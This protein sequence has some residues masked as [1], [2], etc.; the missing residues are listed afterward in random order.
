MNDRPRFYSRPQEP[1]TPLPRRAGR[2]SE[3]AGIDRGAR[4]PDRGRVH[5]G[6]TDPNPPNRKAMNIMPPTRLEIEEQQRQEKRKRQARR[7]RKASRGRRFSAKQARRNH[8]NRERAAPLTR[9]GATCFP[10]LASGQSRERD[11]VALAV[12]VAGLQPSSPRWPSATPLPTSAAIG[13]P[14]SSLCTPFSASSS[15]HSTSRGGTPTSFRRTPFAGDPSSGWGYLPAMLVFALLPIVPAITVFI[16]LHIALSAVAA[17]VLGRLTGFGPAGAFVAGAAYAFP[18]LVP[19]AGTWSSLPAH[20][21]AADSAHR[22]R[23]RPARQAARRDALLA[24]FSPVSPS[25]RSWRPGSAR[26]AYYALLVIGGWVA[27]RTLVTPPSGWTL[28]PSSARS[29]WHRRERPADWHCPERGGASGRASTPTP[30]PMWPVGSTPDSPAGPIPD[31]GIPIGDID[32]PRS[33]GG[34]S[35]ANW[36]YVGAAVAA[37]AFLAP[38]VAPRWPP[39]LFWFARRRGGIILF[40]PERTPSSFGHVRAA[41]EVRDDALHLPERVL[42]YIRLC[43]AMLAGATADAA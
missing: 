10:A 3:T 7:R 17:Y 35:Q 25:A 13:Q 6:K 18:W 36:Q 43:R 26:A 31:T 32:R 29:R 24:W 37:L 23:A 27:W 39:L 34:F 19:A 9:R 12:L 1:P 38:F 2:S 30:G 40:L 14:C 5:Y 4:H 22:R 15:A 28:A 42:L 41:A 8:G 21:L 20:H 11:L 33:I 16:G